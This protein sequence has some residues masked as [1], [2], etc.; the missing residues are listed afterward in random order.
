M[1]RYIFT[2][3][4][5]E[6]ER[7][8]VYQWTDGTTTSIVYRRTGYIAKYDKRNIDEQINTYGEK[9]GK[10]LAEYLAAHNAQLSW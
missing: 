8:L 9:A 10:E 5:N 3:P 2:N 1:R 7:E 6:R 4:K